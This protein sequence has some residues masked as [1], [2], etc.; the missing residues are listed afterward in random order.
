MYKIVA[1]SLVVY[2]SFVSCDYVNSF[3]QKDSKRIDF[4]SVDEYPFFSTCDSLASPEIKQECF[5]KTLVAF[6]KLDL[7]KH[8]LIT[9]ETVSD[10]MI[11]HIA[12]DNN[13]KVALQSIEK[14][15]KKMETSIEIDSI[16]QNSI[17]NIPMLTAAKKGDNFVK[18]TYMIPLYIIND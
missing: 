8:N 12:I 16:I 7:E 10:A 4:T 1:I 14:G 15:N 18:S 11:I 13:G 5:E 6:L 2:L 3:F 9:T 17:E